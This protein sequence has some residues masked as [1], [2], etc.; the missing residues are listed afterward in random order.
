MNE[1]LSEFHFIRP[2]FLMLLIVP[3]VFYA[4]YFRG[5]KNK[6]QWEKV[7]DERLLDFLLIKGSSKS[8]KV[9]SY[10][11]ILAFVSA[12]LA[13]SGPT[14]KK[15]EVPSV[16]VENPVMILLNVSSDMMQ[17]DLPPNRLTRAK[18]KIVDLLKILNTAQV[19]L[20]V[21]SEEPFLIS[22]LTNDVRVIKNLVEAVD[23]NIMPTDGDRLDRALI[24]AIEKLKNAGY[25]SGNIVVF[26]H[27]VG[28]KF[29]LVLDTIKDDDWKNFRISVLSVGKERNDK[30]EMIAKKSGGVYIGISSDDQDIEKIAEALNDVLENDFKLTENMRLSFEDYGYYL[31]FIPLICCLLF[32]RRGILVVA[33]FVIA[34]PKPSEARFLLNKDQW[35]L[36]KYNQGNFEE[37]ADSFKDYRWRGASYYKTGDYEKA[38]EEFLKADDVSAL[39]N[40]GNTL[41]K[42]GK[43]EEAIEKYE[44]VLK[45][46]AKHEDAKFNLEYLKQQQEQQQSQSQSQNN[47]QKQEQGQDQN[48]EEQQSSQEQESSQNEEQEQQENKEQNKDNNQNENENENDENS[49]Q[50]ENPLDDENNGKEDEAKERQ[51][52]EVEQVDSNPDKEKEDAEEKEEGMKA[53][54]QKPKEDEEFDE[55]AQAYEMRYREIP[56]DPGGLLRS[57]IYREY[58]QNRYG[59][60]R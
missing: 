2:W 23:F 33:F 22:P 51:Q 12:V 39:Y 34:C 42:S 29:N 45:K 60:S 9:V 6:S 28:H 3:M 16:E 31:V 44:E 56:E 32:F 7:C 5:A 10:T 53:S 35:G 41:A 24:F 25:A 30:L 50:N 1:F 11:A 18:Y 27:D 37:A 19:G 40:Q 4:K 58:R 13:L 21:Y 49:S 17:R 8:R 57:F 43:I 15:I 47:E 46:D 54:P 26:A 52:K 36:M 14:W 55:Q 48:Q 20:G 38:Y 59:D